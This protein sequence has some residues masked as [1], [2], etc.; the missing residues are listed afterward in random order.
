VHWSVWENLWVSIFYGVYGGL[1]VLG[2]LTE[3]QRYT[4]V[5]C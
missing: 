2:L 1:P 5:H 4:P 3:A